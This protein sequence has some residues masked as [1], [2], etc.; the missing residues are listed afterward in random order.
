LE[1]IHLDNSTNR[2][3]LENI[4]Y[5]DFVVSRWQT[6]QADRLSKPVRHKYRLFLLSLFG[7]VR[8]RASFAHV[9]SFC[10]FIGYPRSGHTLIGSILDA[11]PNCDYR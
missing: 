4:T 9:E 6:A 8:H 10:M 3:P 11:H 2:A 7:G 1:K 5:T